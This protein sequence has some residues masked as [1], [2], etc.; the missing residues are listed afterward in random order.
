[1][2]N[3]L[4]QFFASEQQVPDDVA[5]LK[6]EAARIRAGWGVKTSAPPAP[7]D[8]GT[9]GLV[10]INIPPGTL[11]QQIVQP[12]RPGTANNSLANQYN[13]AYTNQVAQA[14]LQQIQAQQRIQSL[15]ASQ[16]IAYGGSRGIFGV[17]SGSTVHVTSTTTGGGWSSVVLSTGMLGGGRTLPP[18]F[19]PHWLGDYHVALEDA[20]TAREVEET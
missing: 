8:V 19:D 9:P 6:D 3:K 17:G 5:A 13:N 7:V 16:N 20:R 11:I 10:S 15:Q 12:I 1:M 2:I 18:I 4:R 14:N